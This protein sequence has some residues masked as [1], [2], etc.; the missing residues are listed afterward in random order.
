MGTWVESV[1]VTEETGVVERRRTK[2][3]PQ[4]EGSVRGGLRIAFAGGGTGGHIVPGRHLLAHGGRAV[5]DVLWFCTGRPVEDKAFAGLG[6][7]LEPAPLERVPL[8]LEPDGGGAPG[9][10]GLA[11]RTLPAVR[12]ARAALRAHRSQVLVGL[13]GFTCLP[14]VLAARTLGIPVALLEINATRGKATRWLAPFAA[15]VFHAWRGTLPARSGGRD[16]LTG[17]PLAPSF[18]AGGVSEEA[19]AR[20]RQALGFHPE[21]PL[22]VVLGGSQGA[23]ALNTFL[24]QHAGEFSR[25][26]VQVLHQTGPGK[27]EQGAKERDGYRKVEFVHDVHT[28]LAGATLVLCRGGASTLAE[29][30][31][32]RKPAWVVPYPHHADRHQERNA[33][34]LGGGVELVDESRL[35]ASFARELVQLTLKSG[36]RELARRSAELASA[37]PLD[38]ATR[39]WDDVTRIA[40]PTPAESAAR[41]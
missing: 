11:F 22:L 27:L 23:G 38:A 24:A 5:D 25:Q 40:R 7:E 16:V 8:R 3:P 19:A 2:E 29:V 12:A 20:A 28:A 1:R 4:A 15:R 10:G 6:E 41:A 14:A 18:A 9:L 17:P 21:R 31:A 30:A 33:R 13:G 35:G 32:L 39:I 36:T 34:E 26:A 37:M